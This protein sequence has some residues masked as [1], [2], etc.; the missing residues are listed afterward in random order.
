M[1]PESQNQPDSE[2]INDP[3]LAAVDRK[4]GDKEL[5]DDG[6]AFVAG[7]ARDL[8]LIGIYGDLD[9]AGEVGRG[10]GAVNVLTILGQHKLLNLALQ[11]AAKSRIQPP[12]KKQR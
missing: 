5:D 1:S 9:N 7:I 4:V 11:D 2:P 8:T 12:R 3:Y 10:R 6:A